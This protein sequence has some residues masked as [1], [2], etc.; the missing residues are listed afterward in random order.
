MKK[1]I[2]LDRD[3]TINVEK[4]YLHRIEDFVLEKGVIEGLKILRDLGYIFVVVTNQSGIARGYYS[5]EDVILLN[6]QINEI[7]RKDGINIEKFYYCPHHPEK[8]VGKYKVKCSCR[9]PETGMLDEAVKD[10]DIDRAHSYM[11][12]DNISDI[13]AGI[14]AGVKP[15]LVTTGHGM[16]HIDE[17][18]EM[19]VDVFNSIYDFALALSDKKIV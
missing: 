17:V 7:L 5:E 15:I 13:K 2:F 16:E 3:G 8:G 12:G 14:N 10:F 18:K 6:K 4:D 9:K 11:I 1:A 19:G